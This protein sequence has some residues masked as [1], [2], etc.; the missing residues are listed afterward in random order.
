[1]QFVLSTPSTPAGAAPNMFGASVSGRIQTTTNTVDLDNEGDFIIGA[2]GYDV[3]QLSGNENTGGAQIVEGGLITVPIPTANEV[4]TTIGVGTP[5]APFQ[6]NA[7]TPAALPIYV[8]G[9]TTPF[10]FNPTT[11]ISQTSVTVNGVTFPAGANSVTF[12]PDT[13][14]NNWKNGIQDLI[15]TISP[16]SALALPNGVDTVTI[17]G[18][19]NATSPLAGMTWTGSAQVTVTGGSVIPVISSVA[20]LPTGPNLK[21]DFL[22]PYG[23][24][25]YTPSLTALSAFNYQPIPTSVALQQ[26]LIPQGFRQRIYS[27]NHPGKTIGPYLTSRGQGHEVRGIT[28]LSSTVFDRS[29]FH[30]T[31]NYTYTHK[32]PKVGILR[33]VIPIQ[34]KTQRFDDGLVH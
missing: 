6:I 4:V 3:T 30:A 26:F 31:N 21:I 8:F 28:T 25:Q 19:I 1:V 11:D 20:G 22:S 17:S 13:N 12:V 14:K 7:T 23:A 18:T 32:G 10:A 15:V 24:N 5:F 34:E 33:G 27:F 29:R 16:R 9:T 2:P